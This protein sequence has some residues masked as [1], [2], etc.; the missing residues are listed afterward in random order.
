MIQCYSDL[1]FRC[2]FNTI[3]NFASSKNLCTAVIAAMTHAFACAHI[4]SIQAL[5]DSTHEVGFTLTQTLRLSEFSIRLKRG[6]ISTDHIWHLHHVFTPL[7]PHTPRVHVSEWL[8]V[9]HCASH[10]PAL[11]GLIDGS[12][13]L[14]AGQMCPGRAPWQ[15]ATPRLRILLLHREETVSKWQREEKE[16]MSHCQSVNDSDV[17]F[18]SVLVRENY[19]LTCL[20]GK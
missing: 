6:K 5:R 1:L 8:M 14:T 17:V 4:E 12:L 2:L 19:W 10:S 18:R 13:C 7:T 16:W 9:A 3:Y 11:S 20:G 15:G